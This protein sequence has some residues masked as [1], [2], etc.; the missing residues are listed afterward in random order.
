[1]LLLTNLLT[2]T[3]QG[4]LFGISNIFQP[5]KRQM[6]LDMI[7]P[8]TLIPYVSRLLVKQEKTLSRFRNTQKSRK[9]CLEEK[10]VL[11]FRM[12]QCAKTAGII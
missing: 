10:L 9:Y 12:L 1:M 7:H 5:R 3:S 11:L 6:L 8:V 4:A 2:Y